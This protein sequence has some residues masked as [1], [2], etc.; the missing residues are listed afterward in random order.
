MSDSNIPGIESIVHGGDVYRNNVELDFSVNLN[1]Y[2]IPKS[3]ISAAISGLSQLHQYPDPFQQ[4]LRA[5]IAAYED[6]SPEQVVCGSGASELLMQ[7]T[8][9]LSKQLMLKYQSTCLTRRT[10]LS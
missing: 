3:V 4:E 7:V 1:P 10:T 2:P 9:E 6:V 5:R 8:E